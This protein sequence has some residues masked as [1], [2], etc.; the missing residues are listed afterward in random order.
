M[1]IPDHKHDTDVKSMVLEM[2]GDG[3]DLRK[4]QDWLGELL[5]VRS[6]DLYRYKCVIA[7][8][9]SNDPTKTSLYILQGVHDMPEFTYSGQ[10]PEGKP[11]KTQV[12]LI[13][14]KLEIDQY[15]KDF[16]ECATK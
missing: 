14:R 9:S 15:R 8:K 16:A 3:L 4:F 10:W 6:A 5:Q 2:R 1:G 7:V 12:V 13:G 11:I